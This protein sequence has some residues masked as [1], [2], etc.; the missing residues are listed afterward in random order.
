MPR[1]CWMPACR[2]SLADLLHVMLAEDPAQR[3]PPALLIEPG[4]ARARR[5]APRPVRRAQRPL[6]VGGVAA[7]D[8][9]TLAYAIARDPAAGARA[10][11]SGAADHWLRRSL[12][13]A[14]LA[15]R[16][17]EP[18]RRRPAE[19][20][21]GARADALLA[22]QA[23]ALLD[24]LAPLCW[25]GV[26]LW[27]DGIGTAL[28]VPAAEG[29]RAG[30]LEALV[31]AEAAA[32]FAALRAPAAEEQA[33]ARQVARAQRTLLQRGGWAGG[34]ARLRY[35]LNPLLACRS[36]LLGGAKVARLDELLAALE[37]A[38]AG[39]K[40]AGG[41]LLDA[42]LV[43]FVAARQEGGLDPL[44]S[45]FADGLPAPRLAL[46][47]VR[48]LA[49][50]QASRRAGKLPSLAA[51]LAASARP[52]LA[53]WSSRTRRAE[54]EAALAEAA[55]EGDL[56]ALLAVLDDPAGREADAAGLQQAAAAAARIDTTIAGLAEG[57]S[58]Q[59]AIAR[60]LGR[61]I[62]AGLG[63]AALAASGVAALLG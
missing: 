21:E 13:D 39:A 57:A 61:E 63:V 30:V 46:A 55:G 53:S 40:P 52:G 18:V 29:G 62:A 16:L 56:G 35:A 2:R 27:P 23:V 48:L 36:K 1:W 9:R 58:G 34:P 19:V 17:E 38:L 25:E 32:T 60:A 49:R 47:Q 28:A 59:G 14:A 37:A 31:A 51:A 12:D 22:L 43:A 42:E 8:V 6:A 50:L 44:L 54:K 7:S 41:L 20:S 4:A 5:V 11:L 3:P 33:R 45:A 10:L 26:A 15:A 24:P